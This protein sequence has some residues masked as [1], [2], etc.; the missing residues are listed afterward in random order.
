MSKLLQQGGIRMAVYHRRRGATPPPPRTKVTIVGKNRN[1]QEEKS[2]RVNFGTQDFGSQTPVPPPSSKTSLPCRACSV[3]GHGCSLG[4]GAGRM[5]LRGVGVCR[6]VQK[7]YNDMERIHNRSLNEVSFE[8]VKVECYEIKASLV[9]TANDMASALMKQLSRKTNEDTA[10]VSAA[11]QEIS[12]QIQVEPT[13]PEEMQQLKDYVDKCH[14][15]VHCHS[16][17]LPPSGVPVGLPCAPALTAS[18]PSSRSSFHG[19]IFRLVENALV[20]P[21]S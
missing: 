12:E 11:Y 18:L 20:Q 17:P 6:Q 9:K 10:A 7:L 5:P 3:V 2:Y 13:N 16:H 15:K 1:L 14:I 8:L 4:K 21:R 19:T